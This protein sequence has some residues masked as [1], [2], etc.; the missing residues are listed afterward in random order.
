M[1]AGLII[2]VACAGKG[3]ACWAAARLYG[4]TKRESVIIGAL[5]NA[6]G[7]MEL[8]MLNIAL[9]R[10]IIAPALFTI[11]ALMA[12]ITTLLASPVFRAVS[13]KN[14]AVRAEGEALAS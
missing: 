1:L 9:S 10:G 2:L 3:I 14:V 6:R 11:M 13:R 12:I 5:M 4:K 8:I 7:L